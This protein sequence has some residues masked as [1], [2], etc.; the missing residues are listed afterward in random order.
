[1]GCF[2]FFRRRAHTDRTA[3]YETVYTNQWGHSYPA[4]RSYRLP[5]EK[6]LARADPKTRQ[7]LLNLAAAG[8]DAW[9]FSDYKAMGDVL[10]M[11]EKD[12]KFIPTSFIVAESLPLIV[13]PREDGDGDEP[14]TNEKSKLFQ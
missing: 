6:D 2:A 5:D 4:E 7:V 9:S 11:V 12:K 8:M 13:T 3:R 1:M 14:E 10:L